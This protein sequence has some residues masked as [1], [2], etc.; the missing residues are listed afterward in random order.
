V[1]A[2]ARSLLVRSVLDEYGALTR[3]AMRPYLGGGEPRRH[4]YAP[5]ADYPGR[6]G[7]MLRSS[8]CLAATRAF[9]GELRD[10]LG[11]AVSLELLHN[12]FLVHDDIEDDSQERRG[13]PTL[14]ALHGVPIAINVGDA[15]TVT[16]LR[17][18][19]DEQARLGRALAMR[20]LEETLRTARETVEGQAL[21]LGWRR[22]DVLDVTE[23]DYLR[24]ILK[25]S[26][27][28]TV[29]HPL[30]VGALIGSRDGFDLDGLV[31]FGFFLG[32]AFQ[33]QDDLLNLVGDRRRYGKEIDGDIQEGK[34]TLMLI[35]L[36]AH[37]SPEERRELDALLRLPRA[38]RTLAEVRFVRKQMDR[39]GSL[40]HAREIAHG[41][42]G[43]AQSEF[44]RVFQDVADSRDRGFIEAL[45]H[46]VIERT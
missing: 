29:I 18:I 24:M 39:Y 42:A 6:G 35:H 44:D 9:G 33:I 25:K 23:A 26:A 22:D 28:Y 30:R 36:L 20:V 10:G 3:T 34:R 8:L 1:S 5:A 16:S 2:T 19:L 40:E 32:A 12:A 37:A 14:H 17:P 4:L 38:H 21:E 7:R 41:L 13:R 45:T 27:W 43:A 11:A 31:R 15:L 46:W